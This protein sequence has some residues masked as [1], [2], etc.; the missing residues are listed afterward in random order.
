[1]TP[2]EDARFSNLER[3]CAFVGHPRSGHSALGT[4]L[5]AHRHALVSHNLDALACLRT[6]L[7][8]EE[9]FRLILAR[10]RSF[11]AEGRKMGRYSYEVPT[12]WLGHVDE[13]RVIG[14]KRA[15]ASSR[16]LAE[17]DALLRKLPGLVGLPVSVIHHLRNPWDNIA[18]IWQ[19]K[20]TRRGRSLAAVADAYF[21]RADAA[22]RGM[23]VAGE[24]IDVIR[25]FHEELVCETRKVMTG[26]L[27]RLSLPIDETFLDA[28][29]SFLHA[30]PRRTRFDVSW[31]GGLVENIG[32]R[33]Q[34]RD[35]LAHYRF[36]A[37]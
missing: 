7:P 29:E 9:L 11:A 34:H 10:D 32:E 31:P 21:A 33:A 36:E 4:L 14:D 1:M 30:E 27:Q 13:L 12:Q 37:D 23:S 22:A 35:G 24:A 5:N 26:V 8:R 18:S 28:C 20:P 15:G 6:G 3:Y 2:T 25:T 16:H 19:W 17:D